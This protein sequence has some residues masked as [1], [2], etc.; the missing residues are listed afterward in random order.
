[1]GNE[2]GMNITGKYQLYKSG[3][4][5]INLDIFIIYFIQTPGNNYYR[6]FVQCM[7][8]PYFDQNQGRRKLLERNDDGDR[9]KVFFSFIWSGH[10]E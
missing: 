3:I 7:V 6:V 1:L 10:P 9:G 2:E 4:Y 8:A 5:T